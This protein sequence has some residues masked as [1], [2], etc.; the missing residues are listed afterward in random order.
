[1]QNANYV[2]KV[3]KLS[4][5]AVDAAKS[6]AGSKRHKQ[7]K[8]QEIRSFFDKPGMKSSFTTSAKSDSTEET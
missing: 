5:M 7:I 3:F 8:N 2:K 1:M 6:H 4:N